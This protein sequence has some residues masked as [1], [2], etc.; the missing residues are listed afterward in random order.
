MSSSIRKHDEFNG[1]LL[2]SLNSSSQSQSTHVTTKGSVV[3][4]KRSSSEKT[5]GA[6]SSPKTLGGEGGGGG[7]EGTVDEGGGLGERDGG[8]G[9]RGGGERDGLS[10]GL[11]E[12]GGEEEKEGGCG[13]FG[14]GLG[15]DEG[16]GDGRDCG[17]GEGNGEGGGE[18]GGLAK[19]SDSHEDG[20][21]METDSEEDVGSVTAVEKN[22]KKE[23]K[24]TKKKEKKEE[25]TTREE[26]EGDGDLGKV[27][28][29]GD[30]ERG[31][32]GEEG[33]LCGR[34]GGG[35]DGG[36]GG[37][38]DGGG[39]G[40][41]NGGRVGGGS[42][43]GGEGG[44]GGDDKGED[45][46]EDCSGDGSSFA[47]SIGCG[48]GDDHEG[49]RNSSLSASTST[50]GP[51]LWLYARPYRYDRSKRKRHPFAKLRYTRRH[52][53]GRRKRGRWASRTLRFARDG[54]LGSLELQIKICKKAKNEDDA[55]SEQISERD[56]IENEHAADSENRPTAA[57][58]T[59]ASVPTTPPCETDSAPVNTDN[60]TV[61]SSDM[62]ENEHENASSET[63][64]E[65]T[66]AVSDT[67]DSITSTAT[68]NPST[69]QIFVKIWTGK[70]ITLDVALS[71]TIADV[72]AKIQDKEGISSDEF[73][74]VYSCKTLEDRRT[75]ADYNIQKESTLHLTMDL[76]GGVDTR[77]KAKLSNDK[78]NN[79]TTTDAGNDDN[80][81]AIEPMEEDEREKKDEVAMKETSAGPTRLGCEQ[82]GRCKRGRACQN[83]E[84][85][86]KR[87][88]SE[89]ITKKRR[90]AEENASQKEIERVRAESSLVVN[91]SVYYRCL[92]NGSIDNLT[93][94]F[95]KY[96]SSLEQIQ[97]LIQDEN[98]LVV[99]ENGDGCMKIRDIPHFQSAIERCIDE[100]R[101]Q[102]E[103][104]DFSIVSRVTAKNQIHFYD[105][106]TILR[107][108]LEAAWDE[109]PSPEPTIEIDYALEQA[110]KAFNQMVSDDNIIKSLKSDN[111]RDIVRNSKTLFTHALKD[112]SPDDG[113]MNRLAWQRLTAC[114]CWFSFLAN[115]APK[116]VEYF[117]EK[118]FPLL[119][120]EGA[121]AD[122][123]ELFLEIIAHMDIVT[124]KEAENM[125]SNSK[126][127]FQ[128]LC[129]ESD[130]GLQYKNAQ[131][132]IIRPFNYGGLQ[133]PGA[134]L[135][136]AHRDRNRKKIEKKTEESLR[137]M[138]FSGEVSYK[139]NACY[140]GA[141][142]DYLTK[143]DDEA[144]QYL[145]SKDAPCGKALIAWNELGREATAGTYGIAFERENRVFVVGTN[146]TSLVRRAEIYFPDG[147]DKPGYSYGELIT[148]GTESVSS[149][150][151]ES[152]KLMIKIGR[153]LD[154]SVRRVPWLEDIDAIKDESERDAFLDMAL[155][156]GAMI[157]NPRWRRDIFWDAFLEANKM[158][159]LTD[160]EKRNY[161]K[162]W[163]RA[164]FDTESVKIRHDTRKHAINSQAFFRVLSEFDSNIQARKIEESRVLQY[165]ME[166]VD[167][168]RM[169]RYETYDKKRLA[170]EI[171]IAMIK[172][173]RE[174]ALGLWTPKS[175]LK[176]V[177]K[178]SLL[179]RSVRAGDVSKRNAN[180]FNAWHD[181][182]TAWFICYFA[183]H[184][185]CF[186]VANSSYR[187]KVVAERREYLYLQRQVSIQHRIDGNEEELNWNVVEKLDKKLDKKNE[188]LRQHG[189][190]LKDA[191]KEA[192]S[193]TFKIE[194]L[195]IQ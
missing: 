71:D 115:I 8:E 34:E 121:E 146:M 30:G 123:P 109:N 97:N 80:V 90:N 129:R 118:Y 158:D 3:E 4:F 116:C 178:K 10:G 133:I 179:A 46:G 45:G 135:N 72:K 160:D 89:R 54:R 139:T 188:D 17:E 95:P 1:G 113:T 195:H 36:N 143:L 177:F 47:K 120:P 185:T 169:R 125:L 50:Y 91:M 48:D 18:S 138:G 38:D 26:E 162:T 40:G 52:R 96:L 62:I 67:I 76:K 140:T 59:S 99:T 191:R 61:S 94:I 70:T 128:N 75:L 134:V 88:R 180:E 55:E 137:R 110:R 171:D 7:G 23:E 168:G 131:Y 163:K 181:H 49:R 68:N 85:L 119:R 92:E 103:S 154:D 20:E 149:D 24:T 189:E 145:Y 19:A 147:A 182:R 69:T 124:R 5:G 57:V 117:E 63:T 112:C 142:Q 86:P 64:S 108:S 21:E 194:R 165:E 87:N 11:G 53:C 151:D 37:G 186:D 152:T 156:V 183:F 166:R 82:C 39:E 136:R 27:D 44:G 150:H 104:N 167:D 101:K 51:K 81:D 58:D 65:S 31:R 74:L 13:K 107:E 153:A 2:S 56:S 190:T 175:L 164:Q 192:K 60:V 14:N 79:A 78:T 172:L 29:G 25:K 33:G 132:E 100:I 6:S 35:E 28:E 43:G 161:Y 106:I 42:D 114:L 84:F 184:G 176:D 193:R 126:G 66:G 173:E 157:G 105:V 122:V 159:G 144:K 22:E 127:E 83:P 9:L 32:E 170:L 141:L 93:R 187:T 148:K 98:F 174:I 73:E 41:G 16:D 12:G 15:G 77:K 111:F 102:C 155:L 130:W